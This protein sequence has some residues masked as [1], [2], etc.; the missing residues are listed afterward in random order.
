VLV[1]DDEALIRESLT[2]MLTAI[3]ITAVATESGA[4]GLA[5]LARSSDYQLIILD[6]QM[7]KQSGY[8][9]FLELQT[10]HPEI[11]VILSSG[12]YPE[13]AVRAMEARGLAAKL[14]KPYGLQEIKEALKRA[15]SG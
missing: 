11:P 2:A 9:V 5:E 12:F 4:A 14:H 1:I 10:L 3:G 7:P 15:L 13:E 8:E 6:M